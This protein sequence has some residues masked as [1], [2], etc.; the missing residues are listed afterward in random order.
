MSS[1]SEDA[2]P[3]EFLPVLMSEGD[4]ILRN[5]EPEWLVFGGAFSSAGFPSSASH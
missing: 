4:S 1:E 5:S 3:M 2:L